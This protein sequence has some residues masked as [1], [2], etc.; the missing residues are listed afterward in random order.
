MLA[1]QC[2]GRDLFPH[3]VYLQFPIA[4]ASITK[5]L[6]ES[7]VPDSPNFRRNLPN[8]RQNQYVGNP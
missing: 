8:V 4:T 6:A 3:P 2:Q 7:L 5:G 1:C